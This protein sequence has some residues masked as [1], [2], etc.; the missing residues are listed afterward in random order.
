MD[1]Y[2]LMVLDKLFIQLFNC[3][4]LIIWLWLLLKLVMVTF[5]WL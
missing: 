3:C 5:T 2:G 4:G 1:V